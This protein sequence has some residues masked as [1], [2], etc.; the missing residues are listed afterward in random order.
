MSIRPAGQCIKFRSVVHIYSESNNN[1]L[2][3][4][5]SSSR[6]LRTT[7]DFEIITA[8]LRPFSSF[9]VSYGGGVF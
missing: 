1:I 4:G 6:A 2:I 5:T 3:S 9:P 7:S 8:R